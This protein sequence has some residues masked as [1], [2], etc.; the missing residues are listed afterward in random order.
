VTTHDLHLVPIDIAA[1]AQSVIVDLRTAEPH[2]EVKVRL[3]RTLPVHADE[4]SARSLMTNLLGNA[5]KYT[6]KRDNALIEVG[7]AES[8]GAPIFFVRDDGV[9][10]DIK[11]AKRLFKP[12]Q[13]FHLPTDFAGTGVGLATCQRIVR[14][15]GGSIWVASPIGE[16]T[17]VFFTL[18]PSPEDAQHPAIPKDSFFATFA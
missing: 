17:T 8:D 18:G 12:F 7:G 1:V 11:N 10:F 13:R 6:G 15:H 16:G 5:W 9:G 14:R 2:L 3:A 4:G